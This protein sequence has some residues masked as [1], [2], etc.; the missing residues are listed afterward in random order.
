M[1]S[2]NNN[3]N[4]PYIRS[5]IGEQLITFIHTYPD[6]DWNWNAISSN[7]NITIEFIEKYPD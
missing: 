4:D 7:P 2:K 1:N 5:L 6:K 3:R